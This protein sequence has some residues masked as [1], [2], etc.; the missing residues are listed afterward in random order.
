MQWPNLCG[1]AACGAGSISCVQHPLLF[2][3]TAISS[4]DWSP[5]CGKS[6]LVDAL[7]GA[8]GNGR[9]LVR[10]QLDDQV[11]AKSLLGAYVCTAVPGEFVWQPGLLTQVR[12]DCHPRAMHPQWVLAKTHDDI[13]DAQ[14]HRPA[15][16]AC[17]AHCGVIGLLTQREATGPGTR[18]VHYQPAA[19][20]TQ[21]VTRGSW[22]LVEDL[23]LAPPDVLAALVPLLEGGALH[24]SHRSQVIRAAPG[25]QFIATVTAAPGA[26]PCHQPILPLVKATLSCQ[27]APACSAL[28]QTPSF[29]EHSACSQNT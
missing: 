16:A 2:P 29:R 5:G 9:D 7:A 10:M 17:G 12:L 25:F 21:A 1:S 20:I 23:N 13:H 11:D 28:V 4:P 6:A 3:H 8:T 22:L 27:P 15:R 14:L 24:L 18:A 19:T 26:Q